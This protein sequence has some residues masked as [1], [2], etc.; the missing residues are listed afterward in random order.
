MQ[1]SFRV[2]SPAPGFPNLFGFGGGLPIRGQIDELLQQKHD[3][4]ELNAEQEAKILLRPGLAKELALRTKQVEEQRKAEAAGQPAPDGGGGGEAENGQE[5]E[6]EKE[7]EED[8]APG[9]AED[10]AWAADAEQW[11]GGSAAAWHVAGAAKEA[12]KKKM[13]SKTPAPM[14]SQADEDEWN[15]DVPLAASVAARAEEKLGSKQAEQAESP[16]VAT[17][18]EESAPSTSPPPPPP[19]PAPAPAKEDKKQEAPPP[20]KPAKQQAKTAKLDKEAPYRKGWRG[21][22][23]SSRRIPSAHRTAVLLPPT[24][25]IPFQSLLLSL[26]LAHIDARLSRSATQIQT[27]E[28]GFVRLCRPRGWRAG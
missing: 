10:S 2:F 11:G 17:S 24:S 27:G 3:G 4:A 18:P 23:F 22:C 13:T 12:P 14:P 7:A 28:P 25:H 16:A 21:G 26:L 9:S 8:P 6:A 19:P 1:H 5:E 20:A 15:S